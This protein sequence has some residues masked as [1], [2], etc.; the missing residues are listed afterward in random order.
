MTVP[1][2]PSTSCHLIHGERTNWIPC[3]R[4]IMAGEA[5]ALESFDHTAQFTDIGPGLALAPCRTCTAT[6]P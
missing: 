6:G 3:P 2:L 1:G 4:H 5:G